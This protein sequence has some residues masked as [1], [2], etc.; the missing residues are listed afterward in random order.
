M[1]KPTLVSGYF[2]TKLKKLTKK[3]MKYLNDKLFIIDAETD[4]LYGDVLSIAVKVC[5][6]TREIDSFYGARNI[7]IDEI[8]DPWTKENVFD[9]LKNAEMFFDSS[10]ELLNAFWE[11]YLKYYKDYSVLTD[12]PYPVESGIF[13]KCIMLDRD[14]RIP[15]SPFPVYDLESMLVAQNHE[16]NSNRM[17]LAGYELVSHDAMNDVAA[18][19]KIIK[20]KKYSGA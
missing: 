17:K 9:T 10:E 8:S 5:Y 2:Q 6:K 18:I 11:F 3:Q 14:Q 7:K 1:P 19:F 4:G 15:Y 16:K 13:Y 20:D 12:V